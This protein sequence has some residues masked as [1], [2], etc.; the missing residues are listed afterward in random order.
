MAERRAAG[1]V[2]QQKQHGG[3]YSGPGGA[4]D[5]AGRAEAGACRRE[6]NDAPRAAAEAGGQLEIEHPLILLHVLLILLQ[7]GRPYLRSGA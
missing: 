7:R 1:V 4:S 2:P 6:D 3:E 5:R